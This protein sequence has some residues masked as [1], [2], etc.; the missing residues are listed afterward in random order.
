MDYFKIC[1]IFLI[2]IGFEFEGSM[3]RKPDAMVAMVLLFFLGLAISG[4]SSM[5]VGSDQSRSAPYS[6]SAGR[7]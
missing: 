1:A 3:K 7:Y 4:F 5:T 2:N 6:T